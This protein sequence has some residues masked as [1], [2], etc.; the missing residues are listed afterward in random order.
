MNEHENKELSGQIKTI[1]EGIA[2]R[3]CKE[4]VGRV[5]LNL[6]CGP[7]HVCTDPCT[8]CKTVSEIIEQPF[9]CVKKALQQTEHRAEFLRDADKGSVAEAGYKFANAKTEAYQKEWY[10]I[11]LDRM[12]DR[13]RERNTDE[14]MREMLV[15]V[16]QAGSDDFTG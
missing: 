14:F 15:F 9:G 11:L 3:V 2:E 7:D 12:R 1:V 4:I 16:F 8:A 5:V 13:A 6:L 10:H